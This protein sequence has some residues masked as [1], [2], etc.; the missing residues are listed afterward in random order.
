MCMPIGCLQTWALTPINHRNLKNI[1]E[2]FIDCESFISFL[3]KLL[4]LKSPFLFSCRRE[5]GNSPQSK[6]VAATFRLKKG[7]PMTLSSTD[8]PRGVIKS[9]FRLKKSM[10]FPKDWF[11][12]KGTSLY[13]NFQTKIYPVEFP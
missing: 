1:Q 10:A 11:L 3:K 13:L 8:D 4:E 9:T 2:E 5:F 6:R 7:D 12:K